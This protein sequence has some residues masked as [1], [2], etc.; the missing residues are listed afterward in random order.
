ML[1]ESDVPRAKRKPCAE[2]RRETN[3]LDRRRKSGPCM[4]PTDA[5]SP[6]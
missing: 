3:R 5:I 1:F 4:W 6:T 2:A